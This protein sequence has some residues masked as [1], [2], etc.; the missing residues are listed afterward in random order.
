MSIDNPWLERRVLAFGHRGSARLWPE[1]T[2][3]AFRR[4]VDA[5][6]PA[7]ELDLRRTADGQ[8][9]VCHDATVDRT[10]DGAGPVAGRTLAEITELDA[11]YRFVPGHGAEPDGPDGPYPLRGRRAPDLRIPSLRAVLAAFPSTLLTMELKEGPPHA[12]SLAADVADLLAEHDRTDDVIVAAFEDSVLR[13]FRQVAPTVPTA[14]SAEEI[15]AFWGARDLPVVAPGTRPP[16][17]VQVPVTYRGVEVVTRGFVDDARSCGLAVHVWTVDDPGEI[18]WLLD[19]GV[20][21]IMTDRADVLVPILQDRG[22]AWTGR[23]PPP[24]HG[25]A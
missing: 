18:D 3:Y 13:E 7:L 8:I 22:V 4:A 20:D 23:T 19:L 25:P 17:A 9:V 16:V 12:A 11:A 5:G 21:G 24:A 14:T 15:G 6:A 1:N 2:A 10:T